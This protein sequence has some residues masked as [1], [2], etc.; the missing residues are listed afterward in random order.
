MPERA[1]V[2]IPDEVADLFSW[3]VRY[4][5]RFKGSPASVAAF[6]IKAGAEAVYREGLAHA[7]PLPE[8]VAAALT[9]HSRA[10]LHTAITDREETQPRTAVR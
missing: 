7:E 4:D 8:Q 10:A 2:T 6:L 9:E 3:L 1:N 5:G